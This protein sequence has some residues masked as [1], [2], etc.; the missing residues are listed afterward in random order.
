MRFNFKAKDKKGRLVAGLVEANDEKHAASLV[1]EKEL[2]LLSLSPQRK[3][4]LS[5]IINKF[6]NRIKEDDVSTFT[7]QLATMVNAGLPI[8]EFLLILKNQAR[9]AALKEMLSQ[10][11]ADV[12]EGQS[13]SSAIGKYPNVFSPTY[14][15][16]LK[17]G[18]AGGVLDN[19]LSRL[20]DNMEKQVEFKGKVKGA[21]I[22]PVIVVIG[23]VLVAAIMMIFVIPKM[24]SLYSEFGAELPGPT[25]I[26]MSVSGFFAKFWWL[27]LIIIAFLINFL[28]TYRKTKTGRRKIDELILKIPIFGDLQRQVALTELTR[29]LSLL[30]GAGVSILEALGILS[31]ISGNAVIGDALE[32]SAKQVEKGFPLAY[33]FSKHPE[34]FPYILSQMVAVGE[35]TGK[36]SEVLAK[37]SHVFEVES[38]QKVKALTSAIEPI[39]MVV[40]GVG[41]G[42]LVIAV[43]LPIYNLTS[44]F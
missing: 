15:A 8:T 37:V 23:M 2:I 44:Q 11:L 10:I 31:Q 3:D 43:I 29:T 25:K 5:V 26:L 4:N 6:K 39:V 30:V 21:L 40:L 35:E 7:R 19:V 33:A 1:R 42:F 32:D 41:V 12:Q 17:A 36:M 28:I 34:A 18:E 27:M 20:S 24:L 22:Y 14:I 38:D 16:L 13:L 9:G